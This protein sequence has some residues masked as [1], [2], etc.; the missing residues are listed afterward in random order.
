MESGLRIAGNTRPRFVALV[1][2]AFL[3]AVVAAIPAR[4][5]ALGGTAGWSIVSS[6]N[7]E[8]YTW[9]QA[10]DASARDNAWAVGFYIGSEGVYETL[11]ERCDG[12]AWKLVQTPNVGANGD[13]LNGVAAV[14]R[15]EAWAVGY[16]T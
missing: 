8:G 1:C 15:S 10:V 14:S 13:W 5:N 2:M 11:A 9:L 7:A 3:L 6:P 12:S 4:S 16:I